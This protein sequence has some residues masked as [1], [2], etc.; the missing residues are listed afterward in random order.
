MQ[1]ETTLGDHLPAMDEFLEVWECM[2]AERVAELEI[3][4]GDADHV[5]ATTEDE[6][7]QECDRPDIVSVPMFFERTVN[8]DGT[9]AAPTCEDT[10]YKLTCAVGVNGKS[11]SGVACGASTADSDGLEY[12][13]CPA[14]ASCASVKAVRDKTHD[15]SGNSSEPF[16]DATLDDATFVCVTA[17]DF[18][19]RRKASA[20][21]FSSEDLFA[22]QRDSDT[23]QDVCTVD[24]DSGLIESTPA[25][26]EV[27]SVGGAKLGES[28]SNAIATITTYYEAVL[29]CGPRSGGLICS[30]A[31]MV[32]D[33]V[34]GVCTPGS[35]PSE[36]LEEYSSNYG[37]IASANVAKAIAETMAANKPP[38]DLFFDLSAV[39][40]RDYPE[41]AIQISVPRIDLNLGSVELAIENLVMTAYGGASHVECS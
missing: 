31:D 8:A 6:Q 5:F 36:F 26:R 15:T 17:E 34:R 37:G 22:Y 3:P 38:V 35:G 16:I 11:A 10:H 4:E 41:Y 32:C 12:A 1:D 30:G 28:S 25:V 9:D 18:A 20:A 33:A 40:D 24:A 23:A 14:G 13:V 7:T 39:E 2:T 29:P 27:V 21:N 19:S